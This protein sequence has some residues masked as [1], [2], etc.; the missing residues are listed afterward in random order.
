MKMSQYFFL[1]KIDSQLATIEA[2][3]R[4]GLVD[5][6]QVNEALDNVQQQINKEKEVIK[7]AHTQ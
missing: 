4:L 5:T 6:D 3:A 7:C 2:A 1:V